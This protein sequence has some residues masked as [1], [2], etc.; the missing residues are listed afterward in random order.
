HP[1][2]AALIHAC[3]GD[4][5]LASG[6][7]NEAA[8]AFAAGAR[9]GDQPGC[10]HVLINCL[11]QLA[12]VAAIGGRL[13][14]AGDLAARAVIVQQ[15][16]GIPA[17]A[18]PRAAEVA[19]AW[20]NTE[21][22]DLSAARRH[23]QR[24]AQSQAVGNDMTPRVMLALVDARVRRARGDVDGGL[25][26][27]VAARSEAPVPPAWLQDLLR[28]E[29]ADL[30]IAAGQPD[31]AARIVEGLY[32]P[33]SPDGALVLARARMAIGATFESPATTLRSAAA[34]L[35]TQVGGCLLEATRQLDGG[36][37]LRARQA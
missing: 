8:E 25:A 9:A 31:L 37:L 28:I 19:W 34:S 16:S 36:E 3:E 1:E 30:N 17:A 4:L 22:Y 7:L 21:L 35:P 18:C 29:E 15:Q 26:C 12:L 20:V 14:K 24:A 11:G 2:L 6:R 13:R 33:G 27:I 10:E 5:W 32:E 23:A